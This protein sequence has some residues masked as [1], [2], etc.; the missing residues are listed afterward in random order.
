MPGKNKLEPYIESILHHERE[1][2]HREEE[3]ARTKAW[4]Y[5]LHHSD[6]SSGSETLDDSILRIWSD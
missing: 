5:A 3:E 2:E 4:D 6:L 1:V